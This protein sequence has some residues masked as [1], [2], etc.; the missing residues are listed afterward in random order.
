M[1]GPLRSGLPGRGSQV[2]GSA[3]V[4]AGVL[5]LAGCIATK[6]SNGGGGGNQQTTVSVSPATATVSGGST[7]NFTV[8]VTGPSETAVTWSVNGVQNGNSSLGTLTAGASGTNTAVYTAPTTVPTP[9]TVS[10]TA[11][12]VA[13]GTTSPASTVTITKSTV[14]VAL[15]PLTAT[16]DAGGTWDLT[17]TVTGTTNVAVN[18]SVDGILNGNSSV[19][20]IAAKSTS[21]GSTAT[22]TAPTTAPSTTTTATITAT[23]AANVGASA[24]AIATIP[25]IVVTLSPGSGVSIPVNGTQQFTAAVTGTTNTGVTNWQVNSIPGGNSTIGTISSTGLYSAPANLT[26]SP[27]QVTITAVSVADSAVTGSILANVH[28][29]VTVTPATDTIGQT[30]NLQYTATVIGAPSTSDGQAVVWSVSCPECQGQQTGGAFDVNNPGLYLAPQLESGT[31]S[32]PVTIIATSSFDQSQ[33][34]TA[35]MTVQQTDPLGTIDPTSVK[36]VSSC[37]EDSAGGLTGGTCYSMTVTCD[38]IAPLTTYLKVN[39]ATAPVGTVLFLIGGGGSGLYDNNPLWANGYQTV[40]KVFAANFNTVQISFG[41]PFDNGAQPNGWLQGP[42][43]VRR[44]ACRYATVADWVYNNPQKINSNSSATNSAPM[45]A[46][47][48]SE[49]AGALGYAAYQYGLAG[50]AS[51]GPSQ[52]FAMIEPTSGPLMTRLDLGCVCNNQVNAPTKGPCKSD[53]APAPMCYLPSQTQF[54]DAAYQ[55][56]G[57]TSPTLCSNGLSGVDT[58][59]FNRFASDSIDSEPFNPIPIPLS[60]TVVV[61]TRFGGLDQTTAKPQG[62]DWW[63]AVRPQ[64]PAQQCTEDAPVDIPSEA[65]GAT[66]IANDII[67]NCQ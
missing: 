58:T 34:A 45:C 24:S 43:G 29:T 36:T 32:V 61:I 66:D 23:A 33:P 10:V 3:I 18:W 16:I 12:A 55:T 15:S 54:I 67:G 65:D 26:A 11:T 19:G 63:N 49:G 6:S 5:F 13:N 30:A 44:L 59:N 17:A 53:T 57:Q 41:A 4:F 56:Q 47:G 52:E 21:T 14:A 20:T 50:K 25:P 31:T 37:P 27:T 22:Y 62:V 28:V 48:N 40:E 60:A 42:G 2:V 9:P 8:T 7:Q 64:P 51:T 39:A 46:T 38:G 1:R 35:T